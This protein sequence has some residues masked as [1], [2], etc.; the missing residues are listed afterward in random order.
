M[1]AF[2]V[3]RGRDAVR[4]RGE[5]VKLCGSLMRVIWHYLLSRTAGCVAGAE[6]VIARVWWARQDSNLGPTDY[7]SIAL[8]S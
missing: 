5:I 3:V 7:E 1:V 8:T 6:Q 2:A 4:V